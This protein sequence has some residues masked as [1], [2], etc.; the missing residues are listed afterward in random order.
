MKRDELKKLS[1]DTFFDN[2][3]GGITAEGHRAF[4][5][6]LIDSIPDAVE[7]ATNTTLGKV[8]G[9]VNPGSVGIALDGSMSVNAYVAQATFVI[10]SNNA[11]AAWA[12]NTAGNDYSIVAIA[13]GAWESDTAVNLTS[14]RT[15]AVI[16]LPGSELVF[17]SI[18]GLYYDTLPTTPDYFMDNVTISLNRT[19]ETSMLA[20]MAFYQVGY[21]HR[22]I[23]KRTVAGANMILIQAF[24]SCKNLTSCQ[25]VGTQGIT[26]MLL[27]SGF[28]DCEYLNQCHVSIMTAE[29]SQSIYNCYSSCKKMNNCSVDYVKAST[30]KGNENILSQC[31]D[32][33]GARITT[34]G[35]SGGNSVC[36]ACK[37]MFLCTTE[38]QSNDAY[39]SCESTTGVKA[40]DTPAGGF[41][42]TI[43]TV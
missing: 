23:A 7:T 31:E 11:L 15:K 41:N 40:D 27:V 17:T 28:S 8:K 34:T 14:T 5:A 29:N 30:S 13:R 20:I 39:T 43:K 10:D 3:T 33:I 12:N 2:N 38:C 25:F 6:A 1:N 21:L 32:I 42:R 35:K 22:C 37:R 24:T 18:R 4:N 36:S 16:G 26:S 19:V 9:S